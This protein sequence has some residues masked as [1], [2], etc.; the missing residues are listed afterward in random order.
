MLLQGPWVPYSTPLHLA[1]AKGDYPTTLCLLAGWAQQAQRAGHQAGPDPR[2]IPDFWGEQLCQRRVNRTMKL[3]VGRRD[4]AAQALPVLAD[5]APHG[6]LWFPGFPCVSR[7]SLAVARA[8]RRAFEVARAAGHM[9]V[10]V[11]LSP[12]TSLLQVGHLP[13]LA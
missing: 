5:L 2:T 12:G 6:L 9:G 8:D 3:L 13:A 10:L 4:P 11:L 1:A 7:A